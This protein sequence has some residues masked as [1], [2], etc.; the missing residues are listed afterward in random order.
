MAPAQ[1]PKSARPAVCLRTAR[2]AD[3]ASYRQPSM[4][5]ANADANANRAQ[6]ATTPPEPAPCPVRRNVGCVTTLLLLPDMNSGTWSVT[7]ITCPQWPRLTGNA[8][9]APAQFFLESLLPLENHDQSG[10]ADRTTH[11]H[12][13]IRNPSVPRSRHFRAGR[14][15]PRMHDFVAAPRQKQPAT[16][17]HRVDP[18]AELGAAD[19]DAGTPRHHSRAGPYVDPCPIGATHP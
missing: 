5:A 15:R 4:L 3:A 18:A 10:S 13:R 17:P 7:P 2:L 14:N 11:D 19:P 1:L 9:R 8:F 12:R 16:E 6:A